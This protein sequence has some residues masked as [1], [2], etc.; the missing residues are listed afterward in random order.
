MRHI[1]ER[2]EHFLEEYNTL[3]DI[4][5]DMEDDG[6]KCDILNSSDMETTLDSIPLTTS[7][8][9][10]KPDQ[11]RE[12]KSFFIEDIKE[13]L[14]RIVNFLD[15]DVRGI[16][17]NKNKHFFNWYVL[18]DDFK[19]IPGSSRIFHIKVRFRRINIPETN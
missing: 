1:K 12:L 13:S 8:I 11:H 17:Y 7:L 15:D 2:K 6:F 19:N 9:I 18:D 14:V 4:C 3:K 5:L 16:Y 10:S